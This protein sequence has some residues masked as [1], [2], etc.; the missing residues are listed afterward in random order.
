[1]GSTRLWPTKR[2]DT[3]H[4]EPRL[5]PDES[6]DLDDYARSGFNRGHLKYPA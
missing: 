2:K 3:F 4:E 5:P 1:M 6:A